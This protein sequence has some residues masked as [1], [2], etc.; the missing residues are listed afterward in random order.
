MRLHEKE[1]VQNKQKGKPKGKPQ[2]YT[3]ADV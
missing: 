1:S 3:S 2:A